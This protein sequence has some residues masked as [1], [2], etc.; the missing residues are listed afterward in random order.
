MTGRLEP[1]SEAE[2]AE[3]DW[4]HRDHQDRWGDPVEPRPEDPSRCR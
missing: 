2:R 1:S 4:A 3:E